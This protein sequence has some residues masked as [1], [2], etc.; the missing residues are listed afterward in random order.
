MEYGS[1]NI[2]IKLPYDNSKHWI[3]IK[4]SKNKMTMRKYLLLY[5]NNLIKKVQSW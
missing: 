5:K 4:L 3:T 2:Q 1:H